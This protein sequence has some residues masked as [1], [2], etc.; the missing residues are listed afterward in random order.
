VSARKYDVYGIGN[1]I[2]DFQIEV[3]EEDIQ[4]F[5]LEKGSMTLA[6]PGDHQKLLAALLGKEIKQSSGGSGANT[7][8]ALSQ[9][10]KSVSYGCI[11]GDDPRGSEYL[12]ELKE[13]GVSLFNAPVPG[14]VTGLSVVMITPDAER[15]MSTCLGITGSFA[16]EHVSA[17]VIADSKWIY[18]EGYLFASDTGR[19]AVQHAISHAKTSGTKIAV[20]LSDGFIVDFFRDSVTEAIR[21]ADLLFA[22]RNEALKYVGADDEIEALRALKRIS[23]NVVVTL[24]EKGALASFEGTEAQVEAF[25]V[26]AVD[27][28]G[29]GDMFAAGFLDGVLRGLPVADSA[30]LACFLAGRVVS[31]F[32]ARMK[33]DILSMIENEPGLLS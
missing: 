21:D 14:G 11:V 4:R 2:M 25:P 5:G 32:G 29:A 10:G 19:Q 7:I 27:D 17:E 15:T 28:T 9:L 13:L 6:E 23:R 31:Q 1:A 20:T 26:K 22:N 30:R 16:P 8:I 3:S 24:G 12:D 33:G 18:I